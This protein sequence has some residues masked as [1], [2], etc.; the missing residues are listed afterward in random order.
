ML[1]WLM[2]EIGVTI[3]EGA[4]P[5]IHQHVNALNVPFTVVEDVTVVL[6]NFD[7]SLRDAVSASFDSNPQRI[8]VGAAEV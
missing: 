8:F 4:N 6:V 1:S 7:A 5:T 2:M 3:L